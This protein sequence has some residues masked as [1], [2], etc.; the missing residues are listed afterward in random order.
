VPVLK[1][2]SVPPPPLVIVMNWLAGL[3]PPC[4][5]EKLRVVTERPM[6]GRGVTVTCEEPDWPPALAVTATGFAVTLTPV[7]WAD[8]PLGRMLTAGLPLLQLKLGAVVQFVALTV[9]VSVAVCVMVRVTGLG[10]TNTLCT[11]HEGSDPLRHPAAAT[12]TPTT[13][14]SG[15]QFARNTELHMS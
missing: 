8:S 10:E 1:S 12:I 13:V 11:T 15:G 3:A 9:A 14:K 6:L 2:E 7:I 5:A 4:I